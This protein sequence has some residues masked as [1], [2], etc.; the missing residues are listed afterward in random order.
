MV[1]IPAWK[2]GNG[3]LQCKILIGKACRT[4]S[5]DV[6]ESF[7]FIWMQPWKKLPG[8]LVAGLLETNSGLRRLD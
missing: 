7:K 3:S 2:S 5:M 4:Q 6:E 1:L 8:G